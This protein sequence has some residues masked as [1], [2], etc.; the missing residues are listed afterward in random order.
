LTRAVD[1]IP[2]RE[3]ASRARATAPGEHVGARVRDVREDA[4][5]RWDARVDSARTTRG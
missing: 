4:S 5:R 2:M 1:E 3:C